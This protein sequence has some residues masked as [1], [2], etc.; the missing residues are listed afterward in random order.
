MRGYPRRA[1]CTENGD[2]R[3]VKG[4]QA[5]QEHGAR[6]QSA[7]FGAAGDGGGMG[8]RL[9]DRRRGV[10]HSPPA[11]AWRKAPERGAR[12]RFIRQNAE[13]VSPALIPEIRLHLATE[14]VPLWQKTEEELGALGLPP[15]FW[16]FAWAGG[17]GLA[18]YILDH[19]R[20]V[21]QRSIID[22]AAGSGL[23]AIAAAIAGAD[24]VTAADI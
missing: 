17:Q 13:I 22:L 7:A 2:A 15:P 6:Q 19:R 10:S 14:S 21:R 4:R 23:V 18:R 1:R 24:A 5:P 11:T 8:D 20:I 9:R 12:E 3:T 16:A